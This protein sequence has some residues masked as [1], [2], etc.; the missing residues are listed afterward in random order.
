MQLDP[1][2]LP[3][4]RVADCA[5]RRRR[6][7]CAAVAWRAA[8]T[9]FA[10][11]AV[12]G[13]PHGVKAV[14]GEILL[15]EAVTTTAA[16]VRLRDI[17]DLSGFDAPTADHLAGIVI[18]PGPTRT[19]PRSLAAS[20]VRQT[21]EQRG[22]TMAEH[23]LGGATRVV[24][25]LASAP[26]ATAATPMVDANVV[27]AAAVSARRTAR[28]GPTD[29][30]EQRLAELVAQ[31]LQQ[32]A[33]DPRPWK[34]AVQLTALPPSEVLQSPYDV[35][36]DPPRAAVAGAHQLVAWVSQGAVSTRI[37]FSARAWQVVPVVV[38]ARAVERGERLQAQD[39][40]LRYVEQV[41][42][43]D[44]AL[45]RLE[46]AIGREVRQPLAADQPLTPRHL[47]QPLLVRKRDPVEVWVRCGGVRAHRRAVAVSDGALG[48]TIPVDLA[49]GTKTQLLARVTDIRTV[50]ILPNSTQTA[51]LR[52]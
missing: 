29:A 10:V 2:A 5:H 1:R 31:Q 21:L 35:R 52:D 38:A 34:V 26:S 48:D 32:L 23:S 20:Q 17:A 40:A 25:R 13:A 7:F 42:D 33:G 6:S 3:A 44:R 45:L 50:E 16:V 47:Q 37:P 22:V 28:R 8:L 46:D 36:V 49:D 27:P 51:A 18:A 15:R 11:A 30:L 12:P 4:S 19:H 9:L 24:V 43:T 14:A 39:V 41:A